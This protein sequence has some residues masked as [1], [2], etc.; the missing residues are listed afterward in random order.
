MSRP[1]I[2]TGNESNN[3]SLVNRQGAK[4]KMPHDGNIAWCQRYN[5]WGVKLRGLHSAR[6]P[7]RLIRP[8]LSVWHAR[9]TANRS[10]FA[11]QQKGTLRGFGLAVSGHGGEVGGQHGAPRGRG[12]HRFL[13]ADD[14][15]YRVQ[16][17][18]AC[19]KSKSFSQTA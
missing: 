11:A 10:G 12:E 1:Q 18:R 9:Q 2:R 19:L 3:V 5:G 4:Y 16:S 6:T 17:L 7:G 14:A 15:A 13:L 8:N